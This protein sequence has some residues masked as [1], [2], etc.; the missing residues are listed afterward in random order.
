MGDL[1]TTLLWASAVGQAA[2]GIG[3]FSVVVAYWLQQRAD[4]QQRARE[5]D[6]L[7]ILIEDEVARNRM[8]LKAMQEKQRWITD[9][10]ATNMRYAVWMESRVRLS[11]LLDNEDQFNDFAKYY[12]NLIVL[13]E[14]RL[15]ERQD[16]S[17][18]QENVAKW[19]TQVLT[20]SKAVDKNIRQYVPTAGEGTAWQEFGPAL[21]RPGM[22]ELQ[23]PQDAAVSPG[24][25]PEGSTSG[26]LETIENEAERATATPPRSDAPGPHSEATGAQRR[27]WWRRWF[28][29]R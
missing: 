27:P 14:A 7:L 3:V 21:T 16:V 23:A 9:A 4:Q 8:Q 28:G 10:P 19:L 13:D 2:S 5:R 20:L 15:D 25:S 17:D 22:S 26:V 29:G 24:T 12:G 18:R 6:G 11:D 1:P